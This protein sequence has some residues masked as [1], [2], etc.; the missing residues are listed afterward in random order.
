MYKASN[1][2]GAL[3]DYNEDKLVF[4]LEKSN[5]DSFSPPFLIALPMDNKYL[6]TD[7]G[8][9]LLVDRPYSIIPSHYTV[10]IG[11]TK[12]K[13]AY[14]D[15]VNEEIEMKQLENLLNEL[16]NAMKE[17]FDYDNECKD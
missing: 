6:D 3:K 5:G 9:V 8:K 2:V 11:D 17:I 7:N 13:C 4:V 1:I 14:L 10:V 12:T 15:D 16:E